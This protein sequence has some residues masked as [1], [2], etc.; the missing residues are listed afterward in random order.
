VRIACWALAALVVLLLAAAAMVTQPFAGK[1]AAWDGPHAE[2][3]RLEETVR[4]LVKPGNRHDEAGMARASA[5]IGERLKELGHQ[6]TIQRYALTAEQLK[7]TR[8]PNEP[9]LIGEYS[10]ILAQ[11]GPETPQRIVVGAHY[12]VRRAYPGA[13]DNASGTASLLELARMLKARP[14]AMRVELAFYSNEERGHI[15]STNAPKEGVREMFSLEMLGCFGE[16]QKFPAPG[17]GLLYPGVEDG[18]VIVGR[19]D[20]FSLV[21][22]VKRGINGSGAMASSIDAPEAIPGIGNSDHDAYWRAGIPAVMITDTAWYR[23]PRY[24]TARDTPETLNYQKMAL[25]T[26]GVA[27]AIRDLSQP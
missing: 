20:D 5:F 4:S 7:A 23:N 24:H 14:P 21:R 11:I 10:N 13:D 15:G 16:P 19:L 8:R 17:M 9:D 12:D 6:P 25:I 1:S 22:A 2:A 26:D 3:A 18:I 27:A